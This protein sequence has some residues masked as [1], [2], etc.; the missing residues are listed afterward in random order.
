MTQTIAMIAGPYLLVTG[1]GF[2]LS[3]GFYQGMIANSAKAD[4]MLVNLSGAVHFVVG[5]IILVQHFHWS[6]APEI[7]VS[8]VGVA[9]AAKGAALIAV[10]ELT[11]KS[12][13]SS[14]TGLRLS[15]A[16]FF[17]VG[18]YLAYIGYIA[19]HS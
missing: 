7:A 1:L 5:L 18:G 2:L 11:L 15:A 14:R 16:G 19:G 4:P 13:K 8:L 17:A 12:P 3:P 10:P 9:A 6:A